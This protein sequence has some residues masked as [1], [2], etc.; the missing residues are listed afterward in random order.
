MMGMMGHMQTA[1]KLM[2][3]TK[4]S[5]GPMRTKRRSMRKKRWRKGKQR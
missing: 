3:N 4:I 1:A 2:P 5:L